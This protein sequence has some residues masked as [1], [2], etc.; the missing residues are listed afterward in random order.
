[1]ADLLAV[2]ATAL[3]LTPPDDERLETATELSVSVTGPASNAAIAASRLGTASAWLSKLSDDALGRRVAGELRRHGVEPAVCW[4]EGRQGL[5][6]VERATTPRDDGRID[7]RAGAAV[8]SLMP[9]DLP[10][11][12]LQGAETLFTSG[13]TL[14][15]SDTLAGTV[16]ELFAAF[17]GRTALALSRSR[18]LDSSV[19]RIESMLSTTNVLLASEAGAAALGEDG[20]PPEAAHALAAAHDLDTVVLADSGGDALVWHERTVHEHDPP[21]TETVDERGA[22]DALC[23]GFLGR[24]IAGD[25]VNEALAAGVAC[26]ALARTVPGPVPLVTPEEVDDTIAMMDGE[27]SGRR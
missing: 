11:L 13:A 10:A 24:R 17:D 21:D 15:L 2:G 20:T 19:A 23:G 12:D 16:E 5:S 25:S 1:M 18:T 9:D 4:D 3:E 14:A 22:F 27:R 8:A 6:F 7:D 26:R